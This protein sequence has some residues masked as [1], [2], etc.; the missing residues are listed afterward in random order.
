MPLLPAVVPAIPENRAEVVAARLARKIAPLFGVPWPDGPFEGRTW[1]SDYAKIT[2]SEIA[3]GAPLP[4]REQAARVDP[5]GGGSWRVV[6]RIGIAEPHAALPNEIANATLNRFGP[7]TRAAAVLTAVNRLLAPVRDAMDT[8]LGLLGG[9][10]G[11][12]LP[13]RL[14]LVAWAGLVIEVFRSQPALVA[15]G[16]HARAIQQEL[17]TAW[18]LPLAAGLDGF[19]LTRCEVAPDDAPRSAANAPRSLEFADL[20]FAALRLGPPADP[21]PAEED[22]GPAALAGRLRHDECVDLL[23][24]RLLAAGTDAEASYL[25]M[26]ERRPGQLAVEALMPPTPVVDRFVADSWRVLAGPGAP[27]EPPLVLPEVPTGESLLAHPVTTRRCVLIALLTM[28]RH[29]QNSPLGRDATRRAI[30]PVLAAVAAAARTA[31]DPDDPVAALTACRAAD[32]TVQTLRPD[33]REDL[34]TAVPELIEGLTRCEDLLAR[35]L[36]DRGA[37]AEAISSACVELN[38]VAQNNATGSPPLDPVALRERVRRSWATF[39]EAL[40][41]PRFTGSGELPHLTP[42]AAYHLNNYAAFL[43]GATDEADLEEGVALFRGLVIPAR[44]QFFATTGHFLPLRHSLQVASRATTRLSEAARARVDLAAAAEWA[45]TGRSWI[46]RALDAEE[47]QHLLCSDPP[48]EA[49]SRFALLAA[50]ALLQA[51]ELGLPEPEG[52]LAHVASLISLVDRWEAAAVGA[53]RHHARHDE[54]VALTARLA[55]ARS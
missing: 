38:A 7:D 3:R 19:P 33:G 11:E 53:G 28:L 8:A 45:T 29:V 10:D 22:T 21:A 47:T 52:D 1:V 51:V 23:L 35:G 14:L 40:E 9:Q 31:L 55:A 48:T 30:V 49:A 5:G 27:S 44:E 16:V 18:R 37:A 24:R 34:T 6:D 43:A 25:W 39:H 41:I 20:T 54:V 50:P 12:P 17:A 2:L 46:H 15:A 13:P 26:S 36:L 32:M 4:T 42:L